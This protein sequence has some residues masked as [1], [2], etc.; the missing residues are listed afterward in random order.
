MSNRVKLNCPEC[1]APLRAPFRL[2]GRSCACPQC[3]GAV[4]IRPV[5]PDEEGPMLAA[6]DGT[7]GMNRAPSRNRY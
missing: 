1:E 7:W 4:Q 6:D 2:I 3:G 5:A